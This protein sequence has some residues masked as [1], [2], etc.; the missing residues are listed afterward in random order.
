MA[1]IA[2]TNKTGQWF[3][4]DKA[5]MIKENTT[6]NGN[7]WISDATGSQWE[8]EYLY[9]TVKG[10]WVL[11]HSSPYHGSMETYEEINN[12]GAAAWMA[13]QGMDPHESLIKEFN[14][15]EIE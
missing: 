8:H 10:R 9:R 12:E 3:D 15:L 7:N 6:Y 4:D 13:K 11:N 1:R 2:L 5:E 14:D